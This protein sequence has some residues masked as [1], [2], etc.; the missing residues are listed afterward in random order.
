MS[1]LFL[2]R[3]ILTVNT[4]CFWFITY[5]WLL[6]EICRLSLN[7]AFDGWRGDE[8]NVLKTVDKLVPMTQ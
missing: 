2:F 8:E 7:N 5:V 3:S 1:T 4:H 6:N